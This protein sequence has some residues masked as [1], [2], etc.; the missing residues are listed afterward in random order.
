MRLVLDTNVLVAALV[1]DGLCRDLVRKRARAHTLITSPQLLAELAE[2][3]QRKF[4]VEAS[5]VPWLVVYQERAEV[6]QPEALPEAICRDPDDDWV[7]ATAVAGEAEIIVTGD[8]DLLEL[9]AYR[10]IRILSPRA[11][12][13]WLDHLV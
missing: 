3:L 4:G 5:Q 2:I 11:F 13:E 7:L 9:R 12:V 6:V 8:A 10:D 1:A